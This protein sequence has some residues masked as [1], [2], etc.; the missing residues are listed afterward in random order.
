MRSLTGSN[1]CKGIKSA[2]FARR[3]GGGLVRDFTFHRLGVMKQLGVVSAL[4]TV[5]IVLR[6][7]NV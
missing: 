1:G 3:F 7:F 6:E 5:V 4:K 2:E